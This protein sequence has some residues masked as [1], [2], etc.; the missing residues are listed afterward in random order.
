MTATVL[1][2]AGVSESSLSIKDDRVELLA[3]L[4]DQVGIQK[5]IDRL[6]AIKALMPEK[7]QSNEPRPDDEAA[8]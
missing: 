6:T 7:V 3:V 2:R 1:V 4:F 8:N 5:I